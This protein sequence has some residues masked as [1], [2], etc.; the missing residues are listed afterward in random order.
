MIRSG[1]EEESVGS[2]GASPNTYFSNSPSLLLPFSP[3]F[4]LSAYSFLITRS[5]LFECSNLLLDS[6]NLSL[7][8]G[9]L[10]TLVGNNLLGC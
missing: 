3:F 5:S 4:P 7:G 6:G 1:G 9:L 10:S 8:I 2:L